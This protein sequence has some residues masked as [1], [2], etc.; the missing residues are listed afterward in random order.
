MSKKADRKAS[1]ETTPA[2]PAMGHNP[3]A[4]VSAGPGR[5]MNPPGETR[6]A[7][8]ALDDVGNIFGSSTSICASLIRP[9]APFFT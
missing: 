8:V 5:T 3:G 4:S 6:I 2:A 7:E 9:W 1:A